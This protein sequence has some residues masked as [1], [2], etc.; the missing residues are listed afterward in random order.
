[1]NEAFISS[2]TSRGM[3]RSRRGVG[4]G[5]DLV[6]GG[7]GNGY[8]LDNGAAHRTGASGEGINAGGPD[9]GTVRRSFRSIL[10]QV[11]EDHLIPFH[12]SEL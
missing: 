1:M 4:I 9:I 6:R 7:I 2:V 12:L 5:A 8:G 10:T 11:H 3:T